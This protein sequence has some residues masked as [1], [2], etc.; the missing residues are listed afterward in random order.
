M[1]PFMSIPKILRIIVTPFIN[2]LFVVLY[3]YILY[4]P[5]IKTVDIFANANAF[6]YFLNLLSKRKLVCA[7]PS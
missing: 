7:Q 3:I 1:T 2:M 6:G 4:P 5:T